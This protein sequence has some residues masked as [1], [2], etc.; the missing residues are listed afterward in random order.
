MSSTHSSLVAGLPVTERKLDVDGLSTAI[1]EGG[2]GRPVVLLQPEFRAVWMRVVPDLVTTHRVIAA[3]LPGLGASVSDGRFDADRVLAWLADLIGQT[4][5]SAP[6]LVGKGPAGALAARYAIDHEVDRLVLVDS[7]GL[8]P[9]RPPL[10]MIVSFA[11]VMLRPTERRLD[12]SF[13]K[14]CYTDA[15]RVRADMGESYDALAAYALDL[16]RTPSFRTAMRRLGSWMSAPIPPEAL[17]RIT[18]PTALIW[19]RHDVG[20]PLRVA[21]AASARFGWPLHVIE[22][23]RDDPG[24][25]QPEAFLAAFRAFAG[26]PGLRGTPDFNSPT[27]V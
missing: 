8:A 20:M 18:V 13:R 7:H 25:E 5:D 12:K 24:L 17:D 27:G 9:F 15:D 23:A 10:G 16:F 6:I 19:G 4:C 21:E 14:Y 11:G 1:I 2:A 26:V 22:D 3:D